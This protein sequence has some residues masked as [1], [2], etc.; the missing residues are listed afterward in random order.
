MANLTDLEIANL[1]MDAIGHGQV[2]SITGADTSK[3]GEV[4]TRGYNT[5]RDELLEAFPWRFAIKRRDITQNSNNRYQV[6]HED[7]GVWTVSPSQAGEYYLVRTAKVSIKGK[8]DDVYEDDTLMTPNGTLGAL[9]ASEWAWG[10]NDTLGYSTLYVRLADDADP[11]SKQAA[12]E[13]FLEVDYDDPVSDFDITAPLPG[14][15]IRPLR[16][17]HNSETPEA[18]WDTL[19][20]NL[21]MSN[22]AMELV[23][24]ALHT[25]SELW[26]EAFKRTLR[27]YIAWMVASHLTDSESVESKMEAK[28]LWAIGRARNLGAISRNYRIEKNLSSQRPTSSW[29]AEGR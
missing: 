24:I 18:E 25:D 27:Y 21:E 3:A 2:T 15:I 1:A 29:A 4:L 19:A 12:D 9:N 13:D 26:P 11:D 8:P 6:L 17:A 22:T 28:Y 7:G 16:S 10:D 23:Y 5:F 20:W 14:D